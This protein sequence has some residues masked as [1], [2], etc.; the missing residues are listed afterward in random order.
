MIKELAVFFQV[1]VIIETEPLGEGGLR[2]W[3]RITS[4]DENKK[5][6]ITSALIAA[7]LTAL[8]V[9]PLATTVTKL[10]ERAINHIF[11]DKETKD[12]EKEKLRLEIIKLRKEI[13]NQFVPLES[14]TV[15]KKKKSNFYEIL[16][17]YPKVTQVSFAVE[18]GENVQVIE[19]QIVLRKNFKDFILTS[20]ALEPVEIDNAVIEIISPVLKK[21]NFKWM[22]IY[23]N[24]AIEFNMKSKEFKGMVQSGQIQFKNGTSINCLLNIRK[25]IDN[26]G[27]VKIVGYDVLRVNNYF[28][29]NTPIE[30]PEGKSHRQKKEADESQYDIFETDID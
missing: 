3:L 9:S 23:N 22:G 25:K 11:E 8:L 18:T 27:L 26:E 16:N 6:P 7:F 29:N 19:E 1:E 28:E 12:L 5:A 10:V 21:G 4:K 17:G 24:A 2:R 13:G 15:I 14:N 20:D 30:T